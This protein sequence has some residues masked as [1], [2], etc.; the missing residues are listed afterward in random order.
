MT[1]SGSHGGWGG[2]PGGGRWGASAP[3]LPFAGIPPEFV[4]QIQ[5][6]IHDE[7]AP[8]DPAIAFS[9]IGERER[10]TLR[11]F[12]R[13]HAPALGLALA[14][15]AAETTAAFVG[16]RLTGYAIDKGVLAGDLQLLF[17]VAGIYVASILVHALMNFAR[18]SWTGRLGQRLMYEL[19]IRVF[20]QL[21]RLSLDFYTRE[22]AGRLM[23]RMT[24]D[25]EALQQLFTEGFVNLSVQVIG[26]VVMIAFMA[27]MNVPLTLILLLGMGPVMVALTLWFR[28]ASERTFGAVRD[29]IAD[30]LAH[31]QESLAGVRIV[32]MHNRQRHNIR[33]H[34]NV[35]GEH[36][37]ANMAAARV[38]AIYGPGS[39]VVGVGAQALVLM[40][41][42]SMV[43]DGS[44]AVGEL[45]A[46]VLYVP[47][48]FNP[49][50]QLVQL[51]NTY[52]LGRAAV[53][54]LRT[55]FDT[56]PSV[57][58]SPS[59]HEL[60]PVEGAIEFERV[61][62][63]YD[64][65]VVDGDGVADGHGVASEDGV[66]YEGGAMVLRDLD[67]EI[68]PGETLALVGNTGAGKSTIVKLI[69]RL[70][71]PLGGRITIDG[72]DLRELSL[73]S[74]RSQ[75]GAVPQEPFLFAG[76]IRDNIAFARPDATAEEVEDACRAVGIQELIDRLPHGIES[77]CHE[78]GVTLSSGERQLIALA[79]AFLAQP[80]ILILDEA[81]SSLD[82]KTEAMVERALDALLGGRTALLIAHRL[83]TAMRADRIAVVSGYHIAEIGS[84]REL[85]DRHGLYADMY[86]TWVRHGSDPGVEDL[87]AASD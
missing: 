79:R 64:R 50:Q 41:G 6:L 33:E 21:Q 42:G 75:I 62:F 20:S 72:H 45:V 18:I 17:A 5:E 43:F 30:V 9:H 74:L 26:L 44:L 25:I 61:T 78:R 2:P 19:R 48:F 65:R 77:L 24:S 7:P 86:R 13:P 53:E 32:A 40:I 56:Q 68:E 81:T 35:V 11:H 36:F 37:D 29:R 76:T 80:R 27:T 66:A 46:F 16:P 47:L 71:D 12:V 55:V 85:L 87:V 22:K 34:R 67:L 70:Y 58:E 39:E 63:A 69:T 57:P 49:I 14:L 54:K 83:S 52:Q 15:V 38:Q 3:G 8:P 28:A 73:R 60:P 59:A 10:F 82:L 1:W 31:L 51:H 4:G 23:T 84:H